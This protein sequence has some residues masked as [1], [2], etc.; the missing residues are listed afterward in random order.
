[1]LKID[2]LGYILIFLI[3]VLSYK[4]WKESDLFQLKCIISNKDGKQYC[5]RERSKLQ[6]AA[7]LLADVCNRC[8]KLIDYVYE[9]NSI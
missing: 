1:M 8:Q 4:I 2:I 5:V 9:K 3:M 6:L 7:D